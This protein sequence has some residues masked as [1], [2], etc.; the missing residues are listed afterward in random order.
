MTAVLIIG[1]VLILAFNVGF[2]LRIL[3]LEWRRKR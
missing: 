3:W 1:G 2:A